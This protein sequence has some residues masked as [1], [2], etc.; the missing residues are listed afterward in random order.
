MRA[1]KN[2]DASL[3]EDEVRA[4][5]RGAAAAKLA[6]EADR[7]GQMFHQE[8]GTAIDDT[9]VA[10]VGAHPVSRVCGAARFEAD[11]VR[12]GLVLRLPVERIVIAAVAE[13]KETSSGGEEVEGGFGVAA[14]GLEDSTSLPWPLLGFLQVEQQG[15]P[16]G[17][18]VVAQTA[19][20]V[21][22]IGLEM[23]DCIAEFGVAGAGNFSQFLCNGVPLAQYQAGEHGLMELLI[24]GELSGEKATV[25]SG[26][27][28]FEIIRIETGYF[29]DC[30]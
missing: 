25:E 11:R 28:E 23:K 13:V 30:A 16:D 3:V 29:F 26:E 5:N 22:E 4:G 8:R 17:Q 9:C 10:I 2:V 20:T 21:L 19:W 24:K 27:R 7:R 15:K 14:G 6:I 1:G 18:M 12:R